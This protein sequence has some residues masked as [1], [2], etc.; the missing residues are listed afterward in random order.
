MF[1]LPQ[2]LLV[3]FAFRNPRPKTKGITWS[4]E[5]FSSAEVKENFNWTFLSY[6]ALTGCTQECWGSMLITRPFLE[7]LEGQ[8][9]CGC[10]WGLEESKCNF[11]HRGEKQGQF[12]QFHTGQLHLNPCKGNG[13]NLPESLF[14]TY[15]VQEGDWDSQMELWR[16]NNAWPIS[17]L[18][19][20]RCLSQ[21]IRRAVDAVYF[22]V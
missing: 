20:M 11:Y 4:K 14:Q 3:R 15:L 8:S 19:M 12:R 13:A 7:P 9:E 18:S 2:F 6:W 17:Q 22:E 16:A 5:D 10:S 1:S 21:W